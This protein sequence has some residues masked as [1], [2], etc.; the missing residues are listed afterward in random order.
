MIK[1]YYSPGAC[2][3]APHV[4]LREL[5][6][7]HTLIRIEAGHYRDEDF[8]AIN[9]RAQVPALVTPEGTIL[10]ETIAILGW[11]AAQA[12]EAGLLPDTPLEQARAIELMSWLATRAHG[13]FGRWF[14]PDRYADSPEEQARVKA[15]ALAA[16]RSALV[17]ADRMLPGG[18]HALGE[19][20]SVVDAY[21]VVYALWARFCGLDLSEMP[22]LAAWMGNHLGR[23]AVMGMLKEE[24]LA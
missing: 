10:T 16:F 7:P 1:L 17:H 19:R 12:P 4:L 15:E 9:P 23:P 6:L 20:P 13:E 2:S 24:G 3:M 14:R 18:S 11:I 21:L 5:S 8:L 22:K